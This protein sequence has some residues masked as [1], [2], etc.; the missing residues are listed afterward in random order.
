MDNVQHIRGNNVNL[1]FQDKAFGLIASNHSIDL[2]P[3]EEA[4]KEAY[5]VLN[6]GGKEFLFSSSIYA[7]SSI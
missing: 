6:D 4:F 3:H 5:R 1:P 7:T 2:C